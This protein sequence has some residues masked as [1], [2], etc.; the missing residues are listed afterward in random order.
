MAKFMMQETI[1]YDEVITARLGTNTIAN[2][3]ATTDTAVGKI[4]K[5]AGE[6]R[7][8]LAS[9]GDPIEGFVVGV[10]SASADGYSM[11]SILLGDRK[12]VTFDGLQA[13][14]GTGTIAL[15][16]FVVTGTVVA[17]GTSLAG[18]PAK[19]CKATAQPG[20]AVV[21]TIP[22]TNAAADIKTAIDAALVVAAAAEKNSLFPWRVISL[23][24]A[25]TGAV[26]TTGVIEQ[27]CS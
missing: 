6:S 17:A 3:S 23:G 11:G 4:Y 7:Y 20:V 2:S 18:V 10:E 22:A 27:T 25:G 16:D 19:V 15:G 14:P 24:S 13:T 26:G 9:A 5:L 12:A 21:S 1:P 8:S